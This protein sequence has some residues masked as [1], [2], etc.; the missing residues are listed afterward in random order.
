MCEDG[1]TPLHLAESSAIMQILLNHNQTDLNAQNE[2]GLT[3]LIY[4]MQNSNIDERSTV[5]VKKKN[6]FQERVTGF[7]TLKVLS[8]I[9]L[10]WSLYFQGFPL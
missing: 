7:C 4:A 10:P 6:L 3:V 5:Q 2:E 9:C 8:S 1:N